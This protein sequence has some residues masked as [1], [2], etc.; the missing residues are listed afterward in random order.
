MQRTDRDKENRIEG[1]SRKFGLIKRKNEIERYRNQC[2]LKNRY[3]EI[4][5]D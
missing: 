4:E 3:K 1:C 2:G 5:V